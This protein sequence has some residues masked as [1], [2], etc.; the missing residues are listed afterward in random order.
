MTESLFQQ[1]TAKRE[2][3]SLSGADACRRVPISGDGFSAQLSWDQQF[4]F[5]DEAMTRLLAVDKRSPIAKQNLLDLKAQLA[6]RLL[7]PC[8]QCWLNCDVDRIK[9]ERG[10]CGLTDQIH[11]YN[12]FIHY[13]EE[14]EISPSHTI[15][16]SGCNFRCLFCSDWD[17]VV[18]AQDDPV[19][20]PAQL[21]DKIGLRQAQGAKTVSFV[22]GTPDVNIAGILQSLALASSSPALVW[23][24]NMSFSAQCEALLDGVVDC[25][26]AD[27][28]FGTDQCA[29]RLAGIDDHQDLVVPR[30]LRVAEKT[31]TIVR[32]L[33]MPGH[34]ECCTIPV[35]QEMAQRAPELRLNLMDQ[36]QL[37]KVSEELGHLALSRPVLGSELELSQQVAIQLG[38]R[39]EAAD[40]ERLEPP[41]KP[42]GESI[43]LENLESKLTINEE[44]DL[45]I[46]NLS[47]S[48]LALAQK[49]NPDDENLKKRALLQSK[50]VNSGPAAEGKRDK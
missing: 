34:V 36:Y 23:N 43:P 3:L 7:A 39:I 22:G 5:H 10:L 2:G 19:I 30:I 4:A 27:W 42:S 29:K 16:L 20:S 37:T 31:Y 17:H 25:Y 45:I 28:K 33:V 44:G 32:H 50:S 12:E 35:L 11:C 24:S 9:G 48:F 18:K 1:F 14:I 38:L 21:A 49:L 26:L 6:T 47:A 15:F 8:R 46:E 40:S 41:M 13:G